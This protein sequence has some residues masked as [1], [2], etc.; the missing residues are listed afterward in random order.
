MQF[1]T[2]TGQ[3]NQAAVDAYVTD[4]VEGRKVDFPDHDAISIADWTNEGRGMADAHILSEN[5]ARERA[6]ALIYLPLTTLDAKAEQFRR[7]TRSAE[8][9]GN[10]LEANIDR[11]KAL[12]HEFAAEMVRGSLPTHPITTE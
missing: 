12:D 11:G 3:T 9:K 7:W 4:W 1:T 8:A 2:E 6:V 5:E 10:Y